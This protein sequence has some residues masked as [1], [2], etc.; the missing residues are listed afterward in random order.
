[1]RYWKH[2]FTDNLK[3]LKTKLRSLKDLEQ[4]FDEMKA[5]KVIKVALTP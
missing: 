3:Q 1:M 5:P 2:Y 4:V